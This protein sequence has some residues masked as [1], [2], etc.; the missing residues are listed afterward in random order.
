M[1][2]G[3]IS[4]DLDSVVVRGQNPDSVKDSSLT[5]LFSNVAHAGWLWP[6]Y[7]ARAVL[8]FNTRGSLCSRNGLYGSLSWPLQNHTHQGV[9]LYKIKLQQVITDCPLQNQGSI[10]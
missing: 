6:N 10:L 8:V 5:P 1:L 4:L 3:V 7:R 9:T 2:L